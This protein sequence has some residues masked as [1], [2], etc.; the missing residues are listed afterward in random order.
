MEL[1]PSASTKSQSHSFRQ[2]EKTE[3]VIMDNR[4]QFLKHSDKHSDINLSSSANSSTTT[5][6]GVSPSPFSTSANNLKQNELPG[7]VHTWDTDDSIISTTV[8]S[9]KNLL[10]CGTQNGKILM[11]N[12]QDFTLISTITEDIAGSNLCLHLNDPQNY[13]F[14]AGSDSLVKI[15][16]IEDVRTPKLIK[17]MY[18]SV[19]IGDIFAL[20]YLE[21][22]QILFIGTQ[23]A[24]IIWFKLSLHDLQVMSHDHQELYLPHLRYNK[25][26]DSI[27]P[28]GPNI[29]NIISSKKASKFLTNINLCQINLT[30]GVTFAH[31]GYVYVLKVFVNEINK[32]K[33]P[34][35]ENIL[36][37]GGGDGVINLWAM[38]HEETS[39]SS[40]SNTNSD[41]H[42]KSTI[43]LSGI[44]L[45]KL[46]S[47]ENEESVLSMEI[48]QTYLYVGLS[49]GTINVWDLLTFQLIKSFTIPNEPQ[50]NALKVLNDLIVFS[51]KSRLYILLIVNGKIIELNTKSSLTLH[52][53]E[54]NT[55]TN[56]H[57]EIQLV[58]GGVKNISLY[59]FES[60]SSNDL[61]FHWLQIN[62]ELMLRNLSKLITFKTV[63]KCR[64]AYIDESRNCV[65][66]LIKLLDKFGAYKT[67]V[68]PIDNGNP[69]IISKFQNNKKL[70][71]VKKILYYGH[72]DVVE[73]NEHSD[74]WSTDPFEMVSKNGYLYGRGISDNKGPT[75][76]I[77]HAIGELYQKKQ[78][79]IDITLVIEGEEENGSK[80]FQE[81][82]LEN[83]SLIGDID[84]ILL[85]NSYWLDDFKPCLNY[86]L[87]GVINCSIQIE[88]DKPD[89]HSG[90]DGGIL[91]EPTMDIIQ[92]LNTLV[93]ND[94]EEFKI[95][96]PDFYKDIKS[97]SGKEFE[98][99]KEIVDYNPSQFNL[100]ELLTKWTKPSLTVHKIEVSGPQTDTI[101]PKLVKGSIS[102]RIVPNQDLNSIKSNLIKHLTENFAKLKS[103]NHLKLNIF[104]E[105]EPWLGDYDSLIYKIIYSNIRKNWNQDPLLIREGGSI[106]T[107]RFLEKT[108]GAS[109]CQIPCGQ[110]SDNAHLKDEKLRILNLFKLK[111]IFIDTFTELGTL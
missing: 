3:A 68:I 71:S 94:D 41:S 93:D 82:F 10:I 32:L 1:Q 61:M 92:L 14:V 26:F 74:Q 66:F 7:L 22:L 110:S 43:G 8:A 50:I 40:H 64:D 73:A 76:A 21:S 84:W 107:I 69:I 48:H 15:Y 11:F 28:S 19:D 109:A 52:L 16:D 33:F 60:Q 87:R 18:S 59:K 58:S 35:F 104:H 24:S 70:S 100:N 23:N 67:N 53:F 62:N 36:I 96:I 99:F 45:H 102:V 5:L 25:F 78:L 42:S 75:L 98:L 54:S 91:K 38:V 44:K 29:T 80:H 34:N 46:K 101:I 49:N 81:K 89:R 51:T 88:S 106:P 13:L 37:S 65:K 90:V 111:D 4:I 108:L 47:L 2:V 72:Y 30:D 57:K 97:I 17:I 39:E 27:G 79:D 56:N 20:Y 77:I 31:F 9:S 95:K 105:V 12:L 6:P 86:G 103:N 63:L 85:S 83:I 55:D